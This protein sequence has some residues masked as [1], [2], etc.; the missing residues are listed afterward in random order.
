MDAL[1]SLFSDHASQVGNCFA[2]ASVF[3]QQLSCIS[4]AIWGP[5]L[6]IFLFGLGIYLSI[7]LKGISLR[8]IPQSFALLWQGRKSTANGDITPFQSL[9][10]ALSSTVGTG[11]IAGVAS[12]IALGGPGAIFWMWIT[13]L[14]GM[15]TKYSESL[16]GVHFRETNAHGKHVGGPMYYIKN[17]LGQNWIWLAI[18]FA[19]FGSVTAFG[20]GNAV[21]ANEVTNAAIQTFGLGEQESYW[22][23]IFIGL[24][25]AILVGSVILGGVQRIGAT[26]AKLVPMMALFYVGSAFLILIMNADKLPAAFTTIFD[27]AFNGTAAAGGFAGAAIQKAIQMGMARG[28]FSNESGMGSAPIAHAAAQTNDPVQQGSIAMLGTFIDTIIIC[29]MTA[30]VIVV[31]GVWSSGDSGAVLSSSAFAAGIPY[32]DYVVTIGLIVFAFTTLIGWSYY[33]E[34]CI[35]FLL[36]E[37]AILP[38]RI[39]WVIAIPFGAYQKQAVIWTLADILNGLMVLPNLIALALLSPVIFKLTRDY[40]QRRSSN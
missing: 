13:A 15:A 34:R 1:L 12:A 30:L 25:M 7:G 4:K 20:I 31:T 33:G 8:W 26:A 10:T 28:V 9:M 18:L 38:Y 5:Y 40:Q 32:G 37:K 21:Q 19:I 11:N 6:L 23:R 2:E 27:G 35:E 3:S 24:L 29:T 39:I 16:L 14:I 36:G 17:G 22:P